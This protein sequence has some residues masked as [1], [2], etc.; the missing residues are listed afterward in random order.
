MGRGLAIALVIGAVLAIAGV[1]TFLLL[2][3][4]VFAGMP[5]SSRLLLSMFI[6]PVIIGIVIAVYYIIR[7]T[8]EEE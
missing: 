2:Y 1:G 7:Q 8:W 5:D 6:P 4:V 3:G